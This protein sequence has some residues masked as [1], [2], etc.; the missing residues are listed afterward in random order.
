MIHAR[1]VESL[2]RRLNEIYAKHTGRTYEEVED[3]LDRDTFMTPE[4][5]KA[6]GLIDQVQENRG[7]D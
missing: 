6:W 4:E 1:E 5:A 3:K 7:D 2:K